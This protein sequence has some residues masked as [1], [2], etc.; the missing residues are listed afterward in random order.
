MSGVDQWMLLGPPK[1]KAVR[2]VV[3]IPD[4]I[5]AA[6]RQHLAVFVRKRK[7]DYSPVTIKAQPRDLCP[8]LGLR[9]W[10]G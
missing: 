8:D 6:L 7:I 10:S 2:R 4:A 3:G 9:L 5:I 1:S